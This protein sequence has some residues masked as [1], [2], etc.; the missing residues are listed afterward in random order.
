MGKRQSCC[1]RCGSLRLTESLDSKGDVQ[2]KCCDCR[3]RFGDEAEAK[4][5]AELLVKFLVEIKDILGNRF[6]LKLSKEMG[7]YKYYLKIG[8]LKWYEGDLDFD[9]WKDLSNI[10][11]VECSFH[12]WNE[13]YFGSFSNYG[14]VWD[15]E[16]SFERRHTLSV[17]GCNSFPVYWKRIVASIL[18]L[19]EECE[20]IDTFIHSLLKKEID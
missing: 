11:F 20:G 12:K 2:Y 17:H 16:A 1:P 4:G 3:I 13:T 14:V 15:I 7:T 9:F 5:Y 18:P 6:V 8:F 19:I 10:L